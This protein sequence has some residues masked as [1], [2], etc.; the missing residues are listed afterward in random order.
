MGQPRC[1]KRR[2]ITSMAGWSQDELAKN[3]GVSRTTIA[4]FGGN[5]RIEPATKNLLAMIA[6]LE[7]ARRWF[8]EKH[9]RYAR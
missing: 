2:P 6:S 3:A 1:L 5:T 8:C 4:N 9:K 7:Q